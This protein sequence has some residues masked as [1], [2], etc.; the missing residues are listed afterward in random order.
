MELHE[1]FIPPF[2]NDLL[3][4]RKRLRRELLESGGDFIHKRVAIL[5]GSTTHDVKDMLELFLLHH[6][7][8]CTFYESEYAQYWQDAMFPNPAL[9]EFQPDVVYIHTTNR[10]ISRWPLLTDPPEAV[11]ALLEEEL[12]R[13][14][15]MWDRLA[16]TYPCVIIQNNFEY[17]S[18]RL[19]GNREASDIHG[20]VNF[21]TRL[22][23][24]FAQYAQ[25]HERFYLHDLNYLSASYGLERWSDPFC[26]HMYKYAMAL[27]AIPWLANSVA[28]IVKSLYGKN[29]K[30]LAL[31]LDNTLWGGVVGDDGPE[32]LQ[33][34]QETPM[35]QAYSEF[36]EYLKAHKQ[37]G[38]LLN[39]I[40]KNDP[41]NALAGLNRPDMTLT[42]EDF[43]LIKA[44]WEPKS[45]NLLDM[46]GELSLL[47]ESFVFV[48]D[49]PAEREIVR[50]QVPGAAV[51]ELGDQPEDYIRAIDRLGC[52]EVTT[53][54]ADDASRTE[55]Y[56]QNA[57]RERA[58]A[59]FSDYGSYL[60]SLEMEADILPFAPMYFSR[61]AQLTNKSNQFNLT[62]RR[63]TQAEIAAMAEDPRTVTLYGRLSDKFGDNGVVSLAAGQLHGERLDVT[64]WLM[65]CRVLK[66]DM[67]YAM[68]DAL[69]SR[70]EALGVKT[71]R[72]FYF[73]TAKN[74]MV[75]DFYEKQGFRK[76]S[77]DPDGSTVWELSLEGYEQKNH[78]I[79]V[80]TKESESIK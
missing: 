25:T 8:R 72:G 59:S 39:V 64:L 36:Q 58:E 67:E 5:G 31:D 3:V 68:M 43:L 24:A 50:R 48:D 12:D 54:S 37:L 15:Q 57:A 63:F 71:V 74:G 45:R 75:R 80:N 22:N 27:P 42:P 79:S 33:V 60:R 1:K 6:G 7:I 41:E 34:G 66:R 13:Y 21:L 30:A 73:P 10:N 20:R 51:P 47:P 23:L 65:S 49:N 2:S 69:A 35:G 44:N 17:P 40:S 76:I 14:R 16:Q 29:K 46:A 28:N 38:V 9:E 18:W 56:R 77:E 26:W 19:Q 4:K 32:N 78:V 11:D 62:T 52:F 55:M 61:I 70:C 53:L